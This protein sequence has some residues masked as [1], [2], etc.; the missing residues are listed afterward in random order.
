MSF[1]SFL[2]FIENNFKKKGYDMKTFNILKISRIIS[3]SETIFFYFFE[4]TDK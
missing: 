3:E 1:L 4:K 2:E